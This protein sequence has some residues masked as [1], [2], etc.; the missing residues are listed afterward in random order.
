VHVPLTHASPLVQALLSLQSEVSGRLK[1]V[2]TCEGTLQAMQSLASPLP[3]AVS[4][5]TPSM[6]WFPL[7]E[8]SR[9]PPTLQWVVRLQLPP[10]PTCATQLPVELQKNPAEQSVSV[11]QPPVHAPPM[12]G[13]AHVTVDGIW[14]DPD[15]QDPAG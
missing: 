15:E 11:E 13:P 5:Q 9:H 8:H 10:E 2:P 7:V 14:Q 6:Q 4:Q 12:H 3:Q 1:Q